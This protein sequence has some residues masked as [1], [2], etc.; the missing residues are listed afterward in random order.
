MFLLRCWCIAFLLLNIQVHAQHTIAH[1]HT[2]DVTKAD[3]PIETLRSRLKTISSGPEHD[4]WSGILATRTG[5]DDQAIGWF[6]QAIPSLK[7]THPEDAALALRLLA[8]SY[9]R[10][11][12]FARSTTIYDELEQSGLTKDLPDLYR[13]GV[14]DD[15]E[16]ARILAGSPPETLVRT[17]PVHVLTNRDNPLKL[18]TTKLTVNGVESDWLLDTGANQSVISRTMAIKLHLQM[19]PGIAHT[20]GGVTGIENSIR[21]AILPELPLGAATAQ[22]VPL[23]V[24]DDAN[25]TISLGKDEPY[26]ISGIVGLPVLRA[27]GCIT[28]HQNGGFEANE[29]C[30]VSSGNSSLEFH[31]LTPAVQTRVK[32]RPLTFTLDTGAQETTLSARFYEQF[33]SERYFWKRVQSTNGGAGG[34]TTTSAYLVPSLTFA[35]GGRLVTVRS[36]TVLPKKQHSDVDSLFGNMGEDVLQSVSSFTLDFPHMQFVM[37]P[38]KR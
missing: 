34:N 25:L 1:G 3:L 23:L 5:Q 8:D 28:F 14:K 18:I 12:L 10:K 7:R 31:L 37:G 24:L 20:A 35:L 27:L 9:D 29:A 36:L 22:N 19:L 15:A 17:G 21:V 32:T 13:V 6:T 30:N 38:A 11:G 26:R 2:N 16:L 4:F 33:S